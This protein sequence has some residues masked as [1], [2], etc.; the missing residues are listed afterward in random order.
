MGKK[1]CR[2]RFINLLAV[3]ILHNSRRLYSALV[4]RPLRTIH[5]PI[6]VEIVN[7]ETNI[8]AAGSVYKKPKRP[9][10]TPFSQRNQPNKCRPACS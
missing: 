10:K 1:S 7:L 3:D 4:G 6:A 8:S 5:I 2:Q 9:S